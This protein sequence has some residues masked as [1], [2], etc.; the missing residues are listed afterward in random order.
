MEVDREAPQWGLGDALGGFAVGFV[1]LAVA[2]ALWVSLTG[3][4]AVPPGFVAAT[5]AGLWVGTVG[6]PVLASWRKGTRDLA[7]DFGLY[8][9]SRDPGVGIPVGVAS[10][11]LLV[12]LISL[13]I[14]W[15]TGHHDLSK[16]A[17][18]VIG[19]AHGFG[20]IALL[21]LVLVVGAPIAEELFFRG[22]LLRSIQRRFGE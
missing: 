17:K 22:L 5:E 4:T 13:P 1:C 14:L 15:L 18:D 7:R 10:Q 9:R 19:I 6:A 20:S 21:T 3:N 8:M 12:P 2:G 16:P 11:L